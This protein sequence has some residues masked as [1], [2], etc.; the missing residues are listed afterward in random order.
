LRR[1]IIFALV[2]IAVGYACLDLGGR[3][4]RA[5]ERLLAN[6]V[7]NGLAV[8]EIDWA[9]IRVDGLRVAISGHAP[10]VESHDLAL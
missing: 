2:L 7:G 1:L 3:G 4:A 8:L 5:I 9:E 10:D 6:R